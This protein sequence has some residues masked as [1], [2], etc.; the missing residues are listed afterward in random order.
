MSAKIP[1][2]IRVLVSLMASI[3]GGAAACP[4]RLGRSSR[5]GGPSDEVVFMSITFFSQKW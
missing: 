5:N 3:T 4:S 2:T 1:I